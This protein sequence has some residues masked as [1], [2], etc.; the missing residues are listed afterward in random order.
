[1][2]QIGDE[3][4]D[5]S[6]VNVARIERQIIRDLVARQRERY[7][8]LSYDE[9]SGQLSIADGFEPLLRDMWAAKSLYETNMRT[10]GG[11]VGWGIAFVRRVIKRIMAPLIYRQERFNGEVLGAFMVL[12]REQL[13]TMGDVISE[14]KRDIEELRAT[15]YTSEGEQAP[16]EPTE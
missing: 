12:A 7:A 13:Q 9:I 10:R 5:V 8:R 1:M 14:L 16:E 2:F 6:K 15:R 4:V 11:L 3:E